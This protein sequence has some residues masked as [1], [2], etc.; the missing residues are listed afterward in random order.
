MW[1]AFL[2][3]NFKAAAGLQGTTYTNKPFGD[4][5]ALRDFPCEVFFALPA[6]RV[7]QG[8]A[9]FFC[10]CLHM[11]LDYDRLSGRLLFEVLDEPLLIVKKGGHAAG[12]GDG[13]VALKDNPVKTCKCGANFVCVLVDEFFHGGSFRKAA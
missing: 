2:I 12:A 6:L 3:G 10:D 7:E 1:A 13:Q 9:R 4:I 8:P 11:L 5:V